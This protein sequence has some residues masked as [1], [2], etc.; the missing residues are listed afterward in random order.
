M[1]FHQ[2]WKRI[3]V[4][5][6][7]T[8][9]GVICHT[10]QGSVGVL[11]TQHQIFQLLTVFEMK[12]YILPEKWPIG[13]LFFWAQWHHYRNASSTTRKEEKRIYRNN[14]QHDDDTETHP[15]HQQCLVCFC[16]SKLSSVFAPPR[17]QP[18]RRRSSLRGCPQKK[19]AQLHSPSQQSPSS[20]LVFFYS[21]PIGSL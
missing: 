9:G 7:R 18:S 19:A 5:K 4:L 20:R 17:L 1:Q 6:S 8:R 21:F 16:C 14:R 11:W 2:R 10:H 15:N 3:W 13:K 12:L